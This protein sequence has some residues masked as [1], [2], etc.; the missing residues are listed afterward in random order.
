MLLDYVYKKTE[1]YLSTMDKSEYKRIGQ[2]FTSKDTAHFMSNLY[3]PQ[4]DIL[5]ILDPGAGTGILSAALLERLEDF[6]I[7]KVHITL[8]E[9]D[10]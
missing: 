10:V 4:K 7:K 6:D 5:N 1:D 9:N 3:F 8:F 2:F